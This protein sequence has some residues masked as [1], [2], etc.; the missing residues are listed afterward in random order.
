MDFRNWNDWPK[1][2]QDK[3]FHSLY[4]RMRPKIVDFLCHNTSVND[5]DAKDIFQDTMADFFLRIEN[6]SSP[7]KK[8]DSYLFSIA[9]NKACTQYKD[10]KKRPPH[11]SLE[12]IPGNHYKQLGLDLYIEE[13]T[14]GFKVVL[15]SDRKLSGADASNLTWEVL[16]HPKMT[17]CRERLIAKYF[18]ATRIPGKELVVELGLKDEQNLSTA[19][20]KCRKKFEKILVK[21]LRSHPLSN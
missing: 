9:Y 18:S 10:F 20:Y 19:L 1:K 14:D 7:I 3:F 15:T 13:D 16:E 4:K 12:D 8:L 2:R 11:Q 6:N 17:T 5:T 21:L